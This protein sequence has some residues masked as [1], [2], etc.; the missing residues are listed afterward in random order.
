MLRFLKSFFHKKPKYDIEALQKEA[1]RYLAE[2]YKPSKPM[3]QITEPVSEYSVAKKED[4][5]NAQFMTWDSSE[6]SDDP[7]A[8]FSLANMSEAEMNALRI[9]LRKPIGKTFSELLFQYIRDRGY[10]ETYVYRRAQIDRKL[11]SKIRND[12]NYKPARDTVIAFALALGCTQ[13]EADKLLKSAGFQLSDSSRR[14]ILI[15][16][17]FV[18]HIYDVMAANEL[19]DGAGEKIIGRDNVA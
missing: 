15:E 13:E 5:S 2:H 16:Y 3:A 4:P 18:H 8:G 9:V 11:F 19:L 6:E 12:R 7:L 14:D 10:R 17:C 1:E